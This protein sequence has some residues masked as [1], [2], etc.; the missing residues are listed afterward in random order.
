MSIYCTRAGSCVEESGYLYSRCSHSIYY[1]QASESPPPSVLAV[2]LECMVTLEASCVQCV[3][4]LAVFS[5]STEISSTP[6][7]YYKNYLVKVTSQSV[8]PVSGFINW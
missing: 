3:R 8:F 5:G 1:Y 4:T 7:L 6:D 2:Y